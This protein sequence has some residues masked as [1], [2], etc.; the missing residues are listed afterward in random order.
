MRKTKTY[1]ELMLYYHNTLGYTFPEVYA[2]ARERMRE[3]FQR[4]IETHKAARLEWCCIPIVERWTNYSNKLIWKY[5]ISYE[6][7]NK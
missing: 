4:D 3:S 1:G 7:E 2:R 6:E 5:Q